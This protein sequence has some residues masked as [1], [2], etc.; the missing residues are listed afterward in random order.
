MGPAPLSHALHSFLDFPSSSSSAAAAA[1]A[2]GWRERLAAKHEWQ[3]KKKEKKGK[4]RLHSRNISLFSEGP[5]RLR[6][7]AFF[8]TPIR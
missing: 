7:I 8:R 6:E 1:A 4:G 3:E 2:E 5:N